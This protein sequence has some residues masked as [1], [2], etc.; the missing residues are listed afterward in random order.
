[1]I[2]SS[3]STKVYSGNG[4]TTV[5]PYDFKIVD[6]DHL[7][8][9]IADGADS[10]ANRYTLT[11]DTHYSVSGVGEDSG[12]N[13]TTI[14]VSG[15][16]G[17]VATQLPTGWKIE[18]VRQVPLTQ[19]TDFE[20]QGGFFASTHEDSFDKVAMALQQIQE[21]V[22]RAPKATVASGETGDDILT[23]IFTARD[24]AETAQAAA[25][26]AQAAA[27]L[28]RTHAETAE[29]NAELAETNAELAETN[30]EAARDSALNYKDAASGFA[31]TATNAKNSAEGA[32]DAAL[33]AQ[34]D[35]ESARD[36]AFGYSTAAQDAQG[37][38]ESA[39]DQAL[40]AQSAAEVAQGLAETAQGLAETAQG[41]AET[42][43]GLA[44]AAQSAAEGAADVAQNI[45]HTSQNSLGIGDNTDSTKEIFARNGAANPPKVRYNHST[46]KWEYTNDGTTFKDI[47]SGSGSLNLVDSWDLVASWTPYKNTTVAATPDDFG[48]TPSGNLTASIYTDA[49]GQRYLQIDK[50]A[51]DCQGEGFYL[52]FKSREADKVIYGL[53]RA[54]VSANYVSD[55]IKFFIYNVDDSAL[56]NSFVASQNTNGI[57][58]KYSTDGD[59]D[60]RLCV[61]VASTNASAYT[62]K[63][64]IDRVGPES[65]VDGDIRTYLGALTTTGSW[66]SNTSYEGKYYRRG[67]HLIGQVKVSLSG[68]PNS[69]NLTLNTPSGLT[70]DTSAL[71]TSYSNRS[72][73]GQAT[74][75]G[76]SS[77]YSGVCKVNDA[78]SLLIQAVGSAGS[79]VNQTNVTQAVPV[80]FALN[81]YII[82]T[83]EVP[84]TEWANQSAVLST[85][86]MLNQTATVNAF[87]T[88]D[89]TAV[90]ATPLEVVFD[91]ER[92]DNQSLYSTAN[93]RFTAN[94]KM[95][96]R[97]YY[98]LLIAMGATAAT[99]ID[100]NVKKNGTG[101][102]YAWGSWNSL[103][104]SKSYSLTGGEEVELNAGD[105]IS[106][107]VSAAG[108]NVTVSS[109]ATSSRSYFVVEEIPDFSVYGVMG[110][111]EKKYAASSAFALNTAGFVSGEYPQM[112]GNSVS[113]TKGEW[114]LL[115]RVAFAIEAGVTVGAVTPLWASANGD[116]TNSTPSQTGL[117]FS[118]GSYNNWPAVAASGF[119]P[120]YPAPTTVITVTQGLT[121]YLNPKVAFSGS[122]TGASSVSVELTAIRLQ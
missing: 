115:G 122:P 55:D 84:I 58:F 10:D 44:E 119:A 42:A 117:S 101:T 59:D 39:R 2:S 24:D 20:N 57:T 9:V 4:S 3:N 22:D 93:G 80:T 94:K 102:N 77:L 51:S 48:G 21:Q 120:L 111:Y 110:V 75:F 97:F 118:G 88:S 85:T 69:V 18:I 26:A 11:K 73:C 109:N 19:L 70:I 36:L 46:D 25:E 98:G 83:Y 66:T 27:E 7:V 45:T 14:D 16:T 112:T 32:R 28:A 15:I 53:M 96:V 33:A 12:G 72:I 17:L 29:T 47:G 6:S 95:K 54:L 43:Q 35:A 81:D 71:N 68:A 1:M 79:Y 60:W 105:Y 34:G 37:L 89:V 108:Q 5:F 121:V 41:L 30:A 23:D 40:G 100:I 92:I 82:C 99:Q 49:K 91:A 90:A 86:E 8:V 65:I 107:W 78:S 114:L 103:A 87:R 56:Q 50:A 64:L 31:T 61:H 76:T 62:F 104:N 63:L 113:I 52:S 74:V 13:V 67:A 116:N 38:A 106:V